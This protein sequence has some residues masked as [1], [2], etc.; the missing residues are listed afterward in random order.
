MEAHPRYASSRS[1][2]RRS[3]LKQNA[4]FHYT[5]RPPLDRRVH[6]TA[7]EHRVFQLQTFLR[8]LGYSQADEGKCDFRGLGGGVRAADE[9]LDD[10]ARLA[11][12]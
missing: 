11:R 5:F 8:T 9:D 7:P 12:S 6:E 3:G 4:E 1:I 10:S 2:G